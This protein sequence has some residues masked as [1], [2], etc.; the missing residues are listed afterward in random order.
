MIH[1]LKVHL[2]IN[3]VIYNEKSQKKILKTQK[4]ISGGFF[5]VF[6]LVFSCQ[7]CPELTFSLDYHP[8]LGKILPGI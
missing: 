5:H 8:D 3:K 4:T 6:F 7:P 2:V 1:I